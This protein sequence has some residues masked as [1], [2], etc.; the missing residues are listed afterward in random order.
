[1]VDTVRYPAQPVFQLGL[2]S[3]DLVNES[4]PIVVM[5][6]HDGPNASIVAQSQETPLDPSND[7]QQANLAS[8]ATAVTSSAS[9][10]PPMR[11]L[12]PMLSSAE[13]NRSFEISRLH[14]IGFELIEG[15][16]LIIIDYG[17][18]PKN[19]QGRTDCFGM[20]YRSQQF[21]V[22]SAN[23]R[24]TGSSKFLDMLKPSYQFRVLRR[25]KL[26]NKLP[27]G[28]DYVL[29]L[30]PPSEGDELVFQMTELSLT[31]GIIKWW[32]A[33][34]LHQFQPALTSGHD[35]ICICR[36]DPS[37]ADLPKPPD[38]VPQ[39]PAPEPAPEA[40]D[41]NKETNVTNNE[42]KEAGQ[43]DSFKPQ[44]PIP[45]TAASLLR[46]KEAGINQVYETPKYREIPDYCPVRH[47][48]NIIRLL[49]LIEGTNIALNSA[50][51]VWTL[52]A[53]AKIFDCPNVIRDR[54][55]QWIM[56]ETNTRF[57]EILPEEAIRI[58]F[59]LE[60]PQVTQCAFRILVNELAI[61]E[62]ATTKTRHRRQVTVF[63][64]KIG[65]AGDELNNLIQHAA[66]ALLD[67]IR[68]SVQ[69]LRDRNMFDNKN[70]EEWAH[71]RRIEKILRQETGPWAEAALEQLLLL[72][73]ALPFLVTEGLNKLVENGV[74]DVTGSI[75]GMDNDRA[76][77][78]EPVDFVPLAD[79]VKSLNLEQQLLCPFIYHGLSSAWG[80]LYTRHTKSKHPNSLLV[81]MYTLISN[82]TRAIEQL[83]LSSPTARSN[84][85]WQPGYPVID[86]ILFSRQ[87]K[88][89]LQPLGYQQ[90]RQEIEPQLNLTRHMLLTLNQDE[91]KYLP[92]WAGGYND[93]TGGV[94]EDALPPAELG[95]NGPGPAYHTGLTIPSAP[96]SSTGTLVDGMRAMRVMG[97]T[98]AGSVDVHDS[99]STV[100]RADRVIADDISIAAESFVSEGTAYQDARFEVPAEG[101]TEGA[102]VEM[103]VDSINESGTQRGE[104]DRDSE[105]DNG[106]VVLERTKDDVSDIWDGGDSDSDISL[107]DF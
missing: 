18:D 51:R 38:I 71:L 94:F 53:L 96:S 61:E 41:A 28:V 73:E 17:S 24:A 56:S 27:Q 70:M 89:V 48:N 97:S 93:G 100:Y 95:P 68:D 60:L 104:S 33:S 66:R 10:W 58:G 101:Q 82:A 8:D 39:T 16:T 21:R 20:S 47:R 12:A 81:P 42:T 29:D 11:Q 14:A 103:M 23:L 99:I 88:D 92:L 79:I 85:D 75:A 5:D 26:V 59:A 86:L 65:D 50:S 90:A 74:E 34:M 9:N 64:R 44:F 105:S 40:I 106:A 57:M 32:S 46:S 30:T 35:D 107:D 76:R 7:Q 83:A 54:A 78:V 3:E 19:S 37:S 87:M 67:R 22:H 6:T 15:D 102:A 25:R 63:G 45:P 80:S 52:V 69:E 62:A 91:M 77:Y 4:Q 49:M 43:N 31:P 84:L 55:M 98:T 2:S 13:I 36:I 1:M 72:K